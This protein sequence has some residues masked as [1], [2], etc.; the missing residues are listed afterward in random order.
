MCNSRPR[1]GQSSSCND[2]TTKQSRQPCMLLCTRNA[3]RT[4]SSYLRTVLELIKAL[5][6]SMTKDAGRRGTQSAQ[7]RPA[8]Y[9]DSYESTREQIRSCMI[10][11]R[12]RMSDTSRP[13]HYN[14]FQ[15]VHDLLRVNHLDQAIS[16]SIGLAFCRL[17]GIY[18]LAITNACFH[19]LAVA[20]AHLLPD[21][22]QYRRL[23]EDATPDML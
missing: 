1:R 9:R 2:R 10:L 13:L 4:Q 8:V 6:R 19:C 3:Y 21:T 7:P 5:M 20:I 17:H 23:F 18:C 14:A 22:G 16:N 12:C 15:R 11:L